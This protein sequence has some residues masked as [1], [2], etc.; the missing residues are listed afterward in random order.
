IKLSASPFTDM[1]LM[2]RFQREARA[3]A[4]ISHPNIISIFDIGVEAGVPYI[5][6]EYVR[7]GTLR[8]KL[9]E[10]IPDP[11]AAVQLFIK[12]VQGVAAAHSSGVIH[13]DLKPSNIL[14]REDGRP[15]ITDFGL[16][17]LLEEGAAALS[18]EGMLVGTPAYMAPE[19]AS[20]QQ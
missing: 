10:E 3:I 8:S 16:T 9:R 5:V 13:R 12:V 1:T 7:G 17:R 19:Q 15:M 20:G 11:R 2:E 6:M 18:L 4:R 14:L